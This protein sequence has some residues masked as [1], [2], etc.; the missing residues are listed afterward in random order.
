MA[1]ALATPSNGGKGGKSLKRGEHSTN[2]TRAERTV[3]HG[4]LRLNARETHYE[5]GQEAM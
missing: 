4:L 2:L 5:E 3:K 1:K